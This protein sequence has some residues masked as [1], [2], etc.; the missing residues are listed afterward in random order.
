M[1][2]GRPKP[3]FSEAGCSNYFEAAGAAAAAEAAEAAAEATE[4]FLAAL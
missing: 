1:K 4:A 2:K 3:A